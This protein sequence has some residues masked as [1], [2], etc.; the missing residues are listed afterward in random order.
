MTTLT[1]ETDMPAFQRRVLSDGFFR[2]LH[3]FACTSAL[4]GTQLT[5][6]K[7]MHGRLK[8]EN[9]HTRFVFISQRGQPMVRQNVNAMLRKLGR[10]AGIEVPVHPHMLKTCDGL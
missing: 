3:A 8:R 5:A 9:P 10:S 2:L 7:R 6:C 1:H 4:Q